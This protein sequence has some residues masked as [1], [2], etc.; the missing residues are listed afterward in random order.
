[1]VGHVH[2]ISI[3]NGGVPKVASHECRVL[4]AGLEGDWQ[5]DRKHHGGPER[6]V[7]LFSLEVIE[8]LRSEGH[9]IEPGT[10]GENLT[11]SGIEWSRLTPGARVRIGNET[12]G[13]ELQ[14]A[15]YCEPCATIRDSFTLLKFNRIRQELHPGESRL[16]ARV[17]K[18]G[19]VR[20][21]DGI[22][23]I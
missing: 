10:A 21:G 22:R 11:I 17:L 15:S 9:P 1:M 8:R 6:A 7:C 20:T 3:S 5:H 18:E 4:K 2:Q 14:V 19:V 23:I 13:V 16:Y 12:D